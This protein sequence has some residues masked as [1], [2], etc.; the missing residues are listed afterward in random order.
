[1]E[2]QPIVANQPVLEM[3]E[4]KKNHTV[5]AVIISVVVTAAI[6]GG[7]IYFWQNMQLKSVQDNL[8]TAQNNLISTEQLLK[9]QIS[10]LQDQI[11]QLQTP[12][13][14]EENKKFINQDGQYSFE[15][16][17][18]W[19]AGS[20]YDCWEGGCAGDSS[21]VV[22]AKE[23]LKYPS[24][25]ARV[26]FVV[27]KDTTLD[28]IREEYSRYKKASFKELTVNGL[29]GLKINFLAPF[30]TFETREPMIVLPNP[31]KEG[32]YI[33][34]NFPLG[35]DEYTQKIADSFKWGL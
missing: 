28:K 9:Q 29:V 17:S 14:T 35:E 30:D 1:M 2:N 21:F 23:G 18:G 3:P 15:Y 10:D 34:I 5:L 31:D 20:P 7:G 6:A 32:T 26:G 8:T 22:L 33:E 11:T 16:P 24:R 19:V 12:P 4:M 25:Y 13:K 27:V